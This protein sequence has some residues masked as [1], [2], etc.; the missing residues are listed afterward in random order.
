MFPDSNIAK[1]F[2][3]GKTKYSY[4]VTY[5]LAPYFKSLLNDTLS[6]LDC[7][8]AMFDEFYNKISKQGQMDL[9]V[10]FWDIES[11]CV[12]TWYFN[13]KFHGK[14]AAQDIYEKFNECISELDEN[15]LLQVSSDGPNVNLVF[16]DLLNEHRSDN[17]LSRLINIGTCGHHTT[18]NSMKYGE[19]SSGWKLNKL[20][21]SMYKIFEEAPKRCEKYEEINLVKSSD[22]RLQFC[23]HRS[24]ENEI[25]AKRAIEIWR[26]MVG[27]V[28]FW[29]GLSKSN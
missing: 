9:H 6:S 22:Y 8:V 7:F 3:C 4:I 15:K 16:L 14:A 23:S 2:A 5:G 27:I 29:K 12:A 11:N 10:R 26:R 13:S 28:R 17:E 25:V 1:T 19:N 24:F 20:L 21:Q 18:H